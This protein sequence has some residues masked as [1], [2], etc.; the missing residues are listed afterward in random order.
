[1]VSVAPRRMSRL[2]AHKVVGRLAWVLPMLAMGFS[3][4]GQTVGSRAGR[5]GE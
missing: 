5:L 1:M 4:Q 2:M 3:A